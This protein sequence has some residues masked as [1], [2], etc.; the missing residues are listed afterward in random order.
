MTDPIDAA[1]AEIAEL[2]RRL[3]DLDR[4]ARQAQ[5]PPD[6]PAA[7]DDAIRRLARDGTAAGPGIDNL[8]RQI[9]E[10]TAPPAPGPTAAELEAAL[11]TAA[12]RGSSTIEGAYRQ[13]QATQHR[14][15]AI[16]TASPGASGRV[17]VQ[18]PATSK[19][20]DRL[21][22]LLKGS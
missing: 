8:R 5:R 18:D 1:T 7:F 22:H 14:R 2:R 10:R 12:G 4:L 9:T 17:D 3:A 13:M 19:V 21:D 16:E 20:I 15:D 11:R 6:K